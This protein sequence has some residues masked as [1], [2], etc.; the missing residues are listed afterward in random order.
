MVVTTTKLPLRDVARQLDRS[1]E[2]VRRYIREGKLPAQ[3]LGL[4]WFVDQRDVDRFRGNQTSGDRIGVIE[5]ARELRERIR[6]ESGMID[7]IVLLDELR[8]DR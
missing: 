5:Q 7:V 8:G 1:V 2:Q 4:Q 3:Q 6:R